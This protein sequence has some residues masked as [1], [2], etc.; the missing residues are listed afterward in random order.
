M[1]T[2][3]NFGNTPEASK[4]IIEKALVQKSPEN[5]NNYNPFAK[6]AQKQATDKKGK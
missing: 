3:V 5:P 1:K 2:K 6:P 4:K